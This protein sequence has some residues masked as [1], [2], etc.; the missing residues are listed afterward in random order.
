MSARLYRSALLLLLTLI[1]TH[2]SAQD[3]PP[4][5]SPIAILNAM[6]ELESASD[7]KCAST[8]NRFEDFVFGTPLSEA[9]R[10]AKNA[11]QKGLVSR[12]WRAASADAGNSVAGGEIQP[13][14]D[15][16]A[17]VT[18]K[19]AEIEV[20]TAAGSRVAIPRVRLR[21]Y[22]SI[23]Y[24]L[25]V[26]LAA[27][28]DALI[29]GGERLATLEPEAV[30][31]LK[32]MLDVLSL[33]ALQ[34]ADG[35]ARLGNE[36]E[37]SDVRFAA[38]WERVVGDLSRLGT[39]AP[40]AEPMAASPEEGYQ[41]LLH[42]VGEKLAAYEAYNAIP[43]E[44]RLKLVVRN[45]ERFWARYP[46]GQD[47]ADMEG[48]LGAYFESV[49][50]FVGR[51]LER[52][53]HHAAA[54]GHGILRTEDVE[55]AAAE[56]LPREIDEFEDVKL[57]PR[58]GPEGQ[59]TL[60]SYDC[61]SYRDFG[62]HWFHLGR[63]YGGPERPAMTLDPF[64]AEVFT[65]SVSE[66]GVL[67]AH[68]SGRIA[69]EEAAA[70]RV[71]PE[72]LRRAEAWIEELA[73]RHAKAP[74]RVSAPQPIVSAA[75]PTPAGP[76]YFTD[77]T[78]ESGV[79]FEHRSSRWLGEFRR[80][81][82]SGPPTFSGGGVAAGDVD[83]D[84][85]PDL[86]FVGGAGNALLL[87]DGKGGLRDVTE[88]A[89]LTFRRAGGAAGEARQP[90]IADLDNDGRQDLLITYAN[91][92]HRLYRNLGGGADGIVSFE[93]A[94]ARAGLGGAGRIGGPAVVFDAD[95]DGLL[96]VYVGYFG[97]YLAGALPN[98]S[99]DNKNG[100]PNQLLR[101]RGGL[102]FED[103][104]AASGTADTGWAQA[105]SHTDFDRDGRQDLIVA[106][107]YGRNAFLRNVSGDAGSDGALRFEDVSADLGMTK[108]FHSMN[109]GISDLNAD[110]FPEVYVSNIATMVKDN[111]Y[112]LPDL[113]KPLNFD[114]GAMSTMLVQESNVLYMS[115]ASGGAL[116]GYEP[117]AD[118]ERGVSSTGWAWDGEFFDFDLD[119]D[120]DLYVVNG[121]NEYNV[122]FAQFYEESST[123]KPRYHHLNYNRESNV[124]YV[125][126]GGK[127]TNRSP[128]S[129]AD[130]LGNSRSTA[131][132]DFDSDGDLDVAINN[133]HAPA[134][135]LRNDAQKR[136]GW[137]KLRLEG[138]PG[139]ATN[140]DAVGARVVMTA[141]GGL[142]ALREIQGGSGYLSQNPKE[143][144]FGTGGAPA[145]DLEV[146]WPGGDRQTLESVTPGHVYRLRQG[147]DP[148]RVD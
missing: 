80:A 134:V 48:F 44:E 76:A 46:V 35:E 55:R 112:V 8:A 34:I 72:D 87:G 38:S 118:V 23:A 84:G 78:P 147:E 64:A 104:T 63:A 127:L 27:Q 25:R 42:L 138:D 132:L 53:L 13:W 22:A 143:L 61:D 79:R 62:L 40:A 142:R 94:T 101:N 85:V 1:T 131:Y 102:R 108:A 58:L 96:D 133:F 9:G 57:F 100:L 31:A 29:G 126:E 137:L 110:G 124:F 111:K 135:M 146:T 50:R 17:R 18:E 39:A 71:R 77:V 121:S 65:E 20:E 82:L 91:D 51:L 3:Q 139:R 66:Y 123:G 144:H 106:N 109:V 97:D 10:G 52:S 107:D 98:L 68:L 16:V 21:Q 43:Q 86:L 116:A 41:I 119:G 88:A 45:V 67:V 117:S 130:F 128:D 92:D 54:A 145:V 70:P 120:D 89:G 36:T 99:R 12:L 148:E 115:R 125:N 32:R 37:I 141:A 60:E 95:G 136:G 11:L 75:A 15:R 81:R 105:L 14:V 49:D 47:P 122:L 59:V 90:L 33:A 5:S 28:Q 30:D 113:G 103:V 129:G 26:V 56:V 7:A 4:A 93:D 114:Y 19:D 69:R 73:E 24:S 74:E 6:L 2:A 83:G 140:R